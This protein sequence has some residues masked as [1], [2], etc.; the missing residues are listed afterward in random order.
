M[1]HIMIIKGGDSMV[2]RNQG[3][4]DSIDQNKHNNP[5]TFDNHIILD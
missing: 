4:C 5:W 3:A 2:A 1:T